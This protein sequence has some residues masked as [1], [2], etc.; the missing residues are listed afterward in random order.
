MV[1]PDAA[2][3]LRDAAG[4]HVGF[5]VKCEIGG[6]HTVYLVKGL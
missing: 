5:M 3:H 6:H 2:S 4:A 1:K